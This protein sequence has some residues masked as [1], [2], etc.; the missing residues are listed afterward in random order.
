VLGSVVQ[1]VIK[2]KLIIFVNHHLSSCIT[3]H[4][5]S[6]IRHPPPTIHYPS[7]SITIHHPP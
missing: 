5:P 6:A 1:E 4:P 7:P 2:K 3:H